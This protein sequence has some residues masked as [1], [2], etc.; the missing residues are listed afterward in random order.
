LTFVVVDS[1]RS[2]ALRSQICSLPRSGLSPTGILY[3]ALDSQ[4]ALV[5]RKS[6]AAVVQLGDWPL[7]VP[8]RFR[9]KLIVAYILVRLRV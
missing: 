7:S 1:N 6:D 2:S 8:D 4:V 9:L 3:L 5:A